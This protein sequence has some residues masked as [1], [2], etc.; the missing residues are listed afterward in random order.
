MHVQKSLRKWNTVLARQHF[1]SAN[2]G[3]CCAQAQPSPL[4]QWLMSSPLS[5]SLFRLIILI[6]PISVCNLK[7]KRLP[8]LCSSCSTLKELL[9]WS[10]VRLTAE[11]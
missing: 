8:I 7:V 10:S 11:A 3:L 5:L 4:R 1:Y 9:L 2:M 6:F